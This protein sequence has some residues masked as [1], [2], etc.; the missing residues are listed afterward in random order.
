MS[1]NRPF[2]KFLTECSVKFGVDL[3][4]WKYMLYCIFSCKCLKKLWLDAIASAICYLHFNSTCFAVNSPTS[5]SPV[6]NAH[7]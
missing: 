1:N 7:L 3:P 2:S 6:C 5:I 4:N